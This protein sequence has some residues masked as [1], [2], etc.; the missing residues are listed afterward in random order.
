MNQGWK[1]QTLLLSGM[2]KN[3]AGQVKILCTFLKERPKL[4]KLLFAYLSRTCKNSAGQVNLFDTFPNERLNYFVIST[5][6][7][8]TYDVSW[9]WSV[10]TGHSSSK[11]WDMSETL[12]PQFLSH[13]TNKSPI[14]YVVGQTSNLKQ[15]GRWLMLP[16]E[17]L[18]KPGLWSRKAQW[19]RSS[20]S[21]APLMLMLLNRLC[22]PSVTSLVTGLILEIMSL[23][24]DA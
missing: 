16:P 8:M 24:M 4:W 7:C 6:S 2:G 9:K 15:P 17:A 23:R 22:G 20:D 13:L 11:R 3:G 18:N 1:L 5:R 21:L 19:P 10:C 14:C 12:I